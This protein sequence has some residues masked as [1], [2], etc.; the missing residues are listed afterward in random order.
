MIVLIPNQGVGLVMPMVAG[1]LYDKHGSR[2]FRPAAMATIAVGFLVLGLL[3]PNISWWIVPFLMLPITM[4]TAIFNPINNATVMSAPAPGAQGCSVRPAG[5]HP[6]DRP[7]PWGDG[8]RDGPVY[9]HTCPGQRPHRGSSP[10]PLL[11]RLPGRYPHGHGS[12]LLRSSSRLLPQDEAAGGGAYAFAGTV[13]VGL[14]FIL[15]G[16][17][18][19]YRRE[20]SM[21]NRLVTGS[22]QS[23]QGALSC[24]RYSRK[25]A[26]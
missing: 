3:A 7:R 23:R 12:P 24:E 8:L 5:D 19:S 2:L 9:V 22:S 15:T 21:Y 11:R 26:A 14:A 20:C 10:G 18:F 4:G 13:A 17:R 25:S 16:G 1:W 6:R